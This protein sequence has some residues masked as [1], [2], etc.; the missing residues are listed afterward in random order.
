MV[1][2]WPAVGSGS[3]PLKVLVAALLDDPLVVARQECGTKE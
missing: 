1:T 3:Q 2:D